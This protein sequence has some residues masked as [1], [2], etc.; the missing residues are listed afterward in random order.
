MHIGFIKE[1]LVDLICNTRESLPLKQS[2]RGILQQSGLCIAEV[3]EASAPSLFLICSS[4]SLTMYAWTSSCCLCSP[5]CRGLR[6][7]RGCCDA[8][9]RQVP[10]PLLQMSTPYETTMLRGSV[11]E[12]SSKVLVHM[13]SGNAKWPCKRDL[14][15]LSVMD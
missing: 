7:K 5:V 8:S 1:Q 10:S 6:R 14:V 2:T 15:G 13:L 9:V 12:Q 11:E 3:I 4:I